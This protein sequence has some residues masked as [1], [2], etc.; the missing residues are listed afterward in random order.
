MNKGS[1]LLL[2][3]AAFAHLLTLTGCGQPGGKA[4]K[5]LAL[6]YGRLAPI[7]TN[8]QAFQIAHDADYFG[9]FFLSRNDSVDGAFG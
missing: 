4:D 7:P 5:E 8:A 1:R 2:H 3:L 9:A 6:S